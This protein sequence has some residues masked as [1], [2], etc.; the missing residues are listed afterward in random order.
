MSMPAP[1]TEELTFCEVH[2]DRETSLRCNKCGRLMCVE[3]AVP[4]PVGYRC[5]QCVRQHEDKFFNASPNDYAIIAAVCAALTGVGAFIISAIGIWLILT[6]IAAIPIGGAIGEAALRATGRRRGR[7]SAQIAGAAALL[8]GLLGG[9][10]HAYSAIQQALNVAIT[11]LGQQAVPPVP[12]EMVVNAVVQDI[13]LLVFVGM[14][15]FFVYS[16]FKMRG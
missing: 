9:V 16:R 3:C 2:P 6:I 12:I 4:T 15:T 5:K 11:Q 1:T 8:G 13:G 14:V 7:Y 10:I